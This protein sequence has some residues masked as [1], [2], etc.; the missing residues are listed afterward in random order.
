MLPGE[1]GNQAPNPAHSNRL[2]DIEA[3]LY[4]AAAWTDRRNDVQVAMT[5]GSMTE[6]ES[7]TCCYAGR[8]E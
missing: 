5:I 8:R 1:P 2:E 7:L 3:L 6:Y 4:A